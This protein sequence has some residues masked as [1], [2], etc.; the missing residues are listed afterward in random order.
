MTLFS[1]AAVVAC[2]ILSTL[3]TSLAVA[4]D[5]H[6][7]YDPAPVGPAWT[8][9]GPVHSVRVAGN[10]VYVG[11]AFTGGVA[12]LDAVDGT[13]IWRGTAN[14]AVRALDLSA[15]GTHLLIGGGFTEVDGATHRKLAS[16]SI[17]NG[18]AE[19]H[20]RGAAG[21]TVRDI[22][23]HGDRV[24][25][26]GTFKAHGGMAQRGLGAVWLATGK[27]VTTFTTATDNHV[28]GL[29]TDGSRLFF[30]GKFT[31]VDGL[32]RHQAASLDLASGALDGWAPARACTGCNLNWDITLG[33]G[34]VYLVGRNSAAAQAVDKI[35]GVRRWQVNANGDGQAVTLAPD[36]LLYVGGHFVS[37]LGEPRTILAALD[38]LT[39]E[40]QMFSA[41]FVTTWPG[42]WALGADSRQLY[43]GGHFTAA[44]P[45][46]NRYPHLAMFP[47]A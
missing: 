28:Y 18:V 14:G 15:D 21:G 27:P 7:A 35:T 19:P 5:A 23:V 39:G 16:L 26:A 13:L 9:D 46:P 44:G 45:R 10:R 32:P 2:A 42:I 6:A 31:A 33:P 20:W 29:A 36:G 1:R 34:L 47:A 30:A 25:F 17:A 22:V 8:P 41:R 12:A 11:G 40:L 38:P 3:V 37:V 43:V 24:Y 4:P